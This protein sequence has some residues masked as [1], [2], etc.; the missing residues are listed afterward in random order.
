MGEKLLVCVGPSPLSEPVIRAT[1][2]MAAHLH[3]PWVAAY[4]ETP[5]HAYRSSEARAHL[6][7][8]LRLA[9]SL[10]AEV[11][12]PSGDRVAEALAV[13]A[14]RNRITRSILG[15]PAHTRWHDLVFGSMVDEV[16]RASGNIDVYAIR[17]GADM[18]VESAGL[19]P[20]TTEQ[21]PPMH[22]GMGV[23]I[24]LLTT[25]LAAAVDRH[26]G[27]TEVIMVYLLGVVLGVRPLSLCTL[28][29]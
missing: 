12:T 7:Q 16:I 20:P 26:F 15:K 1:L 17:G 4:V 27:L 10:G 13:Y 5:Q 19:L 8:N 22:Y 6:T 14:G 18:G 9:E 25:L 3:A 23:L 11:V 2:R 29:G 21:P 28:H 24:L